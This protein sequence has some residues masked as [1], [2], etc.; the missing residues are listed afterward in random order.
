MNPHPSSTTA[1]PRR[2]IFGSG[3][4]ALNGDPAV[5][6]P[7]G[8][9]WRPDETTAYIK[10]NL[11][12]AFPN[13]STYGDGIH[14]G[15]IARCYQTM[16]HKP[17]DSNHSMVAMGAPRDEVLGTTVGVWF[18]ATPDGGWKTTKERKGAPNMTG[19]AALWLTAAGVEKWIERWIDKR[20]NVAV[21]ME[22]LYGVADSGFAVGRVAA[23]D[24]KGGEEIPGAQTPREFWEA[25]WEFVPMS[26]LLTPEQMKMDSRDICRVAA[27]AP[28]ESLLRT[29]DFKAKRMVGGSLFG[30]GLVGSWNG[31]DVYFM[32]GGVSGQVHYPGMGLVEQGAEPKAGIETM[33]AQAEEA[34]EMGQALEGITEAVRSVM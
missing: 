2:L 25:G 27:E 1:A 24:G 26:A 23:P 33:L 32:Q 9:S 29:R 10:Y 14:A 18:P 30:S 8:R 34:A 13:V 6:L 5:A 17:V 19:V 28:K 15:V 22:V 12:F 20:K 7:D 4:L 3:E 21:S 31:R 11:S 16:D